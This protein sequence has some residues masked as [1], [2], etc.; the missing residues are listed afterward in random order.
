M[1]VWIN[2]YCLATHFGPLDYNSR[3]GSSCAAWNEL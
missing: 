3:A 2:W 1:S